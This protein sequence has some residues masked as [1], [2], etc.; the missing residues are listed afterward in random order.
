MQVHFSL[1]WIVSCVLCG[2]TSQP[3]L[4]SSLQLCEDQPR[5]TASATHRVLLTGMKHLFSPCKRNWKVFFSLFCF[6]FLPVRA[7][8]SFNSTSFF[9]LFSHSDLYTSPC[10]L[11]RAATAQRV[12]NAEH[13]LAFQSFSMFT[14]TG[15]PMIS[16]LQDS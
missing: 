10:T 9:P 3:W 11:R 12:N 16:V 14:A 1:Q 8:L 15:Q 2:I 5:T 6:I 7:T 13:H 4:T